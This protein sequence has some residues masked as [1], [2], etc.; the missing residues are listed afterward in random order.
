MPDNGKVLK[1]YALDTVSQNSLKG[2]RDRTVK[3]RGIIS[4]FIVNRQRYRFTTADGAAVEV[5]GQFPDTAGAT[6]DLT[7]R[8]VYNGSK[9][10]LSEVKKEPLTTNAPKPMDP[11]LLVGIGLLVVGGA[12]GGFALLRS[13]QQKG[14]AALQRR[15]ADAER[16]AAEAR[17]EAG[18]QVREAL[19]NQRKSGGSPDASTIVGG[20][21]APK[22]T[23]VSIGSLVVETGPHAGQTFALVPGDN[24][25][26]RKPEGGTHI[27]LDKDREVSGVHGSLLIRADGSA[28]LIDRSTNGSYL[29]GVLVQHAERPV[30]DGA[31]LTIGGTTMRL[32][33]RRA[34]TPPPVPAPA[35]P[36]VSPSPIEQTA[37]APRSS[38]TIVG[39]P[40]PAAPAPRAAETTIGFPGELVIEQGADAGKRF[41]MTRQQMTIGREDADILLTD[42]TISRRHGVIAYTDGAFTFT[43]SGS[44]FGSH[45]NNEPLSPQV[46]HPLQDG[47]QLQLGESTTARFV[48]RNGG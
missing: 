6:Y 40:A 41:A 28:A 45:K 26:G 14:Q 24:K 36:I 32:T 47:D 43:D 30:A 33:L 17:E 31:S 12:G 27:L 11:T 2:L 18:K 10:D 7:A 23:L 15:I 13:S 39:I 25:I 16:A 20:A 4:N 19:A 34:S 35:P 48:G 44:R 21:G 9:Y 5:V 8:V 22:G 46:T 3:V 38:P 1:T 37:P 42:N 29:D